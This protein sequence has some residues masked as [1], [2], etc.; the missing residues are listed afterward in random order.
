MTMIDFDLVL[1]RN[2]IIIISSIAVI[3]R[4]EKADFYFRHYEKE[5]VQYG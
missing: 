5:N 2:E 3:L 4:R 1:L